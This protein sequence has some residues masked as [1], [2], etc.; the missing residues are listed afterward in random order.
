RPRDASPGTCRRAAVY[1][2]ARLREGVTAMPRRFIAATSLAA[3]AA[4]AVTAAFAAPALAKGATRVSIAGPGLARPVTVSAHG[5]AEA[6]P[7][8]GAVLS[9]L[10]GQTGLFIVLFGPGSGTPDEPSPLGTP[11]AAA[12]LGPGYTVTYT[13]PGVTPRPGQADG[14]VRQDVYPRAAGGP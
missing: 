9:A 11:P 6:R 7:G 12:S 5:G 2:K 4:I 3:V 14:Q 10:A 8:Q 1:L 13:V